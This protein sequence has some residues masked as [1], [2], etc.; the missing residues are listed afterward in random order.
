MKGAAILAATVV[1][2]K[3]IGAV[4]KIPLYNMLGDE[5][6][7][8]FLV[9]YTIYNLLLTIS[10][11]GIPVAL[12]RLISAAAATERYN[13]V[14]RYYKI[15]MPAFAIVGAVCAII[16]FVFAKQLA[17]LMGVY[18][19]TLGVQV[20]APAVLFCCIIS[21]YRGYSQGFGNMAPTAISQIME[22]VCKVIIGLILAWLLVRLGYDTPVI[23]AGAIVG[24]T[25][26]LALCIPI[27]AV[28]KKKMDR[29]EVKQGTDVPMS[30]K[31][32][33]K[34]LLK[35]SIPIA[36]GASIFNIIALV[37]T[38]IVVA[39]LQTGAGF[40]YEQA[41]I[42]FGVYG[43]AQSLFSLPS[44]II[45]PLTISIV[46]AIA[47]AI[48]NKQSREAKTITGSSLKL[49][50][51]LAMP[52]GV[53]LFVLANPIFD[54][55]FWNSNENGPLLLAI[56]G[57]ASF[58]VCLQ[59]LT[60]AILQANGYEK[61]TVLTLPLGGIL[62][63]GLNWILVGNPNIGIIGAPIGTLACYVFIFLLN[64][65]FIMWKVKDRPKFTPVFLKPA[66]CT[67]VMGAA[68][69]ASY[70]LFQKI[71][72]GILGTGRMAT[73]VFMVAA[74]VVAIVVYVI[75]IIATHTITHDDMKY[76]PKGE[77]I[78]KLLRIK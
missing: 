11:A 70:G 7:S 63:I 2:V 49:T 66:I 1:I 64:M 43:K 22:V 78:S 31:E 21:V 58:F 60:T 6:T 69:W 25:L 4:Y 48:A 56:L 15:A 8:H 35:V 68:A 30:K 51:L 33:L 71:G 52:A 29:V 77:K 10:T 27:L 76:V 50:N 17:A 61:F 9:T 20:L 32:T 38:K 73:A 40:S 42:L 41:N 72:S 12:S 54:V 65:V 19:I 34:I 36:I 46:P 24:V 37:D 5:G 74:I 45:V 14:R 55:L 44:A 23:S 75:L 28:H 18:E 39:R 62:K 59:L 53:G 57:I 26:G 13:Q 47:A 3:L 67:L 16:M